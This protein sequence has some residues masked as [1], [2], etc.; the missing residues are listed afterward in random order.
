MWE[1]KT[2]LPMPVH[3]TVRQ[4]ILLI[5]VEQRLQTD[6]LMTTNCISCVHASRKAIASCQ[7]DQHAQQQLG[8]LSAC[9]IATRWDMRM[10]S[11][12]TQTNECKHF[13]T[14]SQ[15]NESLFIRSS[16]KGSHNRVG[17]YEAYVSWIVVLTLIRHAALRHWSRSSTQVSTLSIHV[18]APVCTG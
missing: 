7:S 17:E 11:D 15:T 18:K 3:A 8:W 14:S 16:V 10:I 2:R 13:I 6:G 1:V 12:M 5:V 9:N 4:N